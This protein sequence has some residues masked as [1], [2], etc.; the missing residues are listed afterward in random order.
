MLNLFPIQFLTP[1]AYTLLRLCV[2]FILIRL[3]TIHIR[4]RQHTTTL[5]VEKSSG[6]SPLALLCVGLL[7]IVAGTLIFLGFYTQLGALTALLLIVTQSIFSKYFQN[8][9][10][11][12]R[13]FFVLVFLFY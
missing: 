9:E 8:E 7:E 5:V 1:L 10:T 6:P 3:G 4:N 2:G 12:P 13:V 11:L